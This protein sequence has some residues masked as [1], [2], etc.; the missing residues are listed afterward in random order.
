MNKQLLFFYQGTEKIECLVLDKEMSTKLSKLLKSVRSYFFNEDIGLVGH[1]NSKKRRKHLEHFG[2]ADTEGSN[3]IEFEADAFS[4]M[5]RLRILQLSYVR[6]TE[7]YSLFPKSLRLLCW[8]GF[9]MKTI[10]EDLPLEGLVALEMKNSCLER[11]WER[12]K[13]CYKCVPFL[14][15]ESDLT[16]TSSCCRFSDH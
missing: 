10:P 3:N 6:F 2:D 1:G 15:F 12:I 7:F 13:V 11:T 4:R 5:Q 14:S 8:S 9:H 16:F